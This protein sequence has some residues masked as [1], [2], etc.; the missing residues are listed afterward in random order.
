MNDVACARINNDLFKRDKGKII[1]IFEN[2]LRD[3]TFEDVDEAEFDDAMK[4]Y[5][6]IGNID[7]SE[8]IIHENGG[9]NDI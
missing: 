8:Y 7:I 9:E 6:Y 1:Q 3:K 2:I 5:F 4:K